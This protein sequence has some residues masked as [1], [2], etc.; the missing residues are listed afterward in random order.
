[1]LMPTDGADRHRGRAMV[2]MLS[3]DVE[4]Y[5]QV[6]ALSPR[7]HRE[8]WERMPSRIEQN[9]DRVL[10]LLARH[11]ATATFFTLGWIAER[12]P[13]LVRRIVAEG[14]ELASHGYDHRSV[15]AQTRS[16]FAADLH[17][18]KGTLESVGG[19]AVAGYRAP[20]FSIDID[21]PWA[22]EVLMETGHTY[23][24]SLYPVHHDHYGCPGAPR[25][26]FRHHNGLIE[27]PMSTVR[28][29]GTALPAA[30]GG[31]F[32]L[33]PY[34]ASRWLIRH[35][36]RSE[37]QSALFYFHPWEIDPEQPTIEGIT[38]RSRLRH[39]TNL[40][41]MYPKLDRLLRDFRW[42]RIDRVVL[43]RFR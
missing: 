2:N 18:A 4:D 10:D 23:S 19:V 39:Y 6:W 11:R 9:V 22:H 40:R 13:A 41:A 36:N 34:R 27:V 33:L 16:E 8:R 12:H 17:R 21:M 31:L 43:P 7:I 26:A 32:R 29:A 15:K 30:G 42:E 25:L 35:V 28:I 5:F 24:S 20:N 14:H 1:M 37:Q 38:W 3:I